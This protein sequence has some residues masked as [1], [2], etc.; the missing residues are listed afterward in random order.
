MKRE[1]ETAIEA[2]PELKKQDGAESAPELR[3]APEL[4]HA[5]DAGLQEPIRGA[6]SVSEWD[7][8]QN[9]ARGLPKLLWL[10]WINRHV[11]L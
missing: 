8:K 10:L 11:T 2:Q 1:L 3:K 6:V 9:Q 5:N 7:A 4:V